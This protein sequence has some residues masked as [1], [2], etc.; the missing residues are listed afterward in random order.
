MER[1]LGA[2]REHD[3][4]RSLALSIRRQLR[5]KAAAHA[6]APTRP[7]AQAIT[8][9]KRPGSRYHADLG[10]LEGGQSVLN[11]L[12]C[13]D[14][15][16][17]GQALAMTVESGFNARVTLATGFQ[18]AL[19]TVRGGAATDLCIVDYH[20]PG[21]DSASGLAQLREAIGKGKLLV[22][23]GSQSDEDLR[24]ALASG[25]DG[26]LPKSSPPEVIEAAVR[27]VLA[28]GRYIPERVQELAFAP[29]QLATA[30]AQAP[31]PLPALRP[32]LLGP[33]FCFQALGLYPGLLGL[34]CEGFSSLFCFL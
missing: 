2:A 22:F 8:A 25:A 29:A 9:L 11:V 19:E 30:P 23:S 33:G 6:I 32:G 7:A 10:E 18:E 5:R 1:Q 31:E 17:V 12:I 20:I 3:L 28:G 16:L 13:D 24:I 14:H 34:F 15:P 4:D 26:F 21:E 27:L